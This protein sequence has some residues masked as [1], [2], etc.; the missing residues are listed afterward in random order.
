MRS[1]DKF[2]DMKLHYRVFQGCQGSAPQDALKKHAPVLQI[3]ASASASTLK[4]GSKQ[5]SGTRSLGQKAATVFSK[6]SIHKK[7]AY[8]LRAII[9]HAN[10]VEFRR[11]EKRHRIGCNP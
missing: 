5:H 2:P 1:V 7:C 9:S 3:P 11:A 10:C 8:L 4:T 6:S